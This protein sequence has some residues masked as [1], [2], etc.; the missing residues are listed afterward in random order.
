MYVVSWIVIVVLLLLLGRIRLRASTL[1]QTDIIAG[2]VLIMIFATN[3][4][5]K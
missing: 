4:S 5:S 2:N 3:V 1:T